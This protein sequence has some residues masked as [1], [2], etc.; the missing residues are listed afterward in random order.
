MTSHGPAAA[1]S[2]S[3]GRPGPIASRVPTGSPDSSMPVVVRF[4]PTEPGS[5]GWPSAWTRSIA[6]MPSSETARC[7]PPWT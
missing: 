1:L 6:S 3:T 7:G 4:S 5:I 2:S